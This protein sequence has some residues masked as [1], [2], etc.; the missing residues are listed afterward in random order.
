MAR[1]WSNRQALVLRWAL[2]LSMRAY[3]TL[4]WGSL[5]VSAVGCDRKPERLRN[6]VTRVSEHFEYR[7]ESDDSA[8][9]DG[10][11][12][13]LEARFTAL[14]QLLAFPWPKRKKLRYTKYPSVRAYHART[15]CSSGN[16]SCFKAN[17]GVESP[18][19]LHSHELVH[20]LLSYFGDS[21]PLLEEGAAEALSCDGGWL[22]VKR[23]VHFDALR[24]LE[25][26]TTPGEPRRDAY[27]A[28]G[29]LVALLMTQYEPR[30]FREL[31]AA[32]RVDM[33]LTELSVLVRRIYG[34]SLEELWRRAQNTGQ[35]SCVRDFEC[36]APELGSSSRGCESASQRTG[37]R[38]HRRISLSSPGWV[39][40]WS[41]RASVHLG[42]C[43]E[44]KLPAN[45]PFWQPPRRGDRGESFFSLLPA[46]GYFV[47]FIG[48]E[49]SAA[50]GARVVSQGSDDAT[51]LEQESLSCGPLLTSHTRRDVSF[52]MNMGGERHCQWRNLVTPRAQRYSVSCSQGMT[53]MHCAGCGN[54]PCKPIC[55]TESDGSPQVLEIE[56]AETQ[57][58]TVRGPGWLRLARSYKS[59]R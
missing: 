1:C 13:E 53:A 15:R 59:A 38:E 45:Q 56:P 17:F 32:A 33:P 24:R 28:G 42:S 46:G 37:A 6:P 16:S 26:W 11:L 10:L 7:A 44:N 39:H 12:T 47:T 58:F 25:L 49:R 40:W 36:A 8:A 19:A 41:E 9:C 14:H 54:F 35:D 43:Q 52:L 50:Q 18:A 31:Y 51:S 22:A 48:R 29:R 27:A 21:H 5:L 34:L 2:R 30:Q 57:R 20:G 23:V 4:I 55:T 3:A